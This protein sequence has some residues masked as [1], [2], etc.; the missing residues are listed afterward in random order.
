MI[1]KFNQS[2]MRYLLFL[3][4]LFCSCRGTNLSDRHVIRNVYRIYG[5]ICHF[6]I[7]GNSDPENFSDRTPNGIFFRD[8]CHKFQIG[9]TI[10]ITVSRH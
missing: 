9:D 4:I 5:E 10:S 3:L 2:K 1:L 8:S 7:V 6:G